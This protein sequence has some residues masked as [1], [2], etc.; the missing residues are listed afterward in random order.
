M[1]ILLWLNIILALIWV[2]YLYFF[3]KNPRKLAHWFSFIAL[4]LM[5]L[6]SFDGYFDILPDGWT[7]FILVPAMIFLILAMIF[8][9][10]YL[11]Q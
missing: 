3:V 1:D 11:S 10:K 2:F 8:K 9:I 4:N 5:V 6:G 7:F